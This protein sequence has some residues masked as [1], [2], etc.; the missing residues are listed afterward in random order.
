[1]CHC[2]T[3]YKKRVIPLLSSDLSLFVEEDV[4]V[5]S[6]CIFIFD[7]KKK[8]KSC[9]LSEM[10]RKLFLTSKK[11]SVGVNRALYIIDGH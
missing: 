2:K 3:K 8:K 11:V 9:F 6:L 1:M 4:E 5:L 7:G 10:R